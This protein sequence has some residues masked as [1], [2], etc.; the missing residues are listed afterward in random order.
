MNKRHSGTQREVAHLKEDESELSAERAVRG[1]SKGSLRLMS[2]C[3]RERQSGIRRGFA[4]SCV[5]RMFE[6]STSRLNEEESELS[7]ERKVRSILKAGIGHEATL[8]S[9]C[10]CQKKTLWIRIASAQT[11]KVTTGQG[12]WRVSSNS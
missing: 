4:Y 5:V 2:A 9:P 11:A 6:M 7:E 8:A 10:G 3:T 12:E 1:V